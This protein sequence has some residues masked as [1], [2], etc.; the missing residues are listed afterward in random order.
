MVESGA[1]EVSEWSLFCGFCHNLVPRTVANKPARKLVQNAPII[2]TEDE[3]Y[4]HAIPWYCWTPA[5]EG[6]ICLSTGPRRASL[7]LLDPRRVTDVERLQLATIE[8]HQRNVDNLLHRVA[9]RQ[10]YRRP[11]WVGIPEG[12]RPGKENTAEA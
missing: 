10:G 9:S 3:F 1:R 5:R 2:S 8:T 4:G 7:L 11:S 12:D 6:G